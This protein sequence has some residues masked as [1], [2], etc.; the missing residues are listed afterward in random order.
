M[1][2]VPDRSTTPYTPGAPDLDHATAAADRMLAL[3]V[4]ADPTFQV[5][6]ER[7]D[8]TVALVEAIVAALSST[9]G[10]R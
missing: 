3:V 10:D 6:A 7:H 9:R 2:I 1:T 8:A 5:T 4:V